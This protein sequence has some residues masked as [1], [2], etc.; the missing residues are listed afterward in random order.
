MNDVV[1]SLE[2]T[3][4]YKTDGK[5]KF[6]GLFDYVSGSYMWA[7]WSNRRLRIQMPAGDSGTRGTFVLCMRTNFIQNERTAPLPLSRLFYTMLILY[8]ALLRVEVIIELLD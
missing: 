3:R 6:S 4:H 7:F 2:Y 1:F 8:F 5:N